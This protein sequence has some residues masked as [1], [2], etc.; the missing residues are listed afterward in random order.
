[1]VTP[2]DGMRETEI[3]MTWATAA[4][5][6]I[7]TVVSTRKDGSQN[8]ILRSEADMSRV[9]SEMRV[10]PQSSRRINP[11]REPESGVVTDKLLIVNGTED[12][13]RNMILNGWMPQTQRNLNKL[14]PKRIFS[15]GKSG[16]KPVLLKLRQRKRKRRP[17]SRWLLI[18]R[19]QKPNIS[20]VSCLHAT[21]R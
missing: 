8:E 13:D 6:E 15:D 21:N 18:W 19:R 3:P 16:W 7:R 9:G 20:K 4:A 2:N 1:M 14:T 12:L 11:Q 10:M 17:S 5:W